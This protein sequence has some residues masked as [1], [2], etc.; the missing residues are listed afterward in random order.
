MPPFEVVASMFADNSSKRK[1]GLHKVELKESS[2]SEQGSDSQS[3]SDDEETESTEDEKGRKPLKSGIFVKASSTKIVKSVL[4]AQAMVD[5]E[6]TFKGTDFN[7]HE[8][9]FALWVA[10]EMEIILSKASPQEK[11]TRLNL[12]KHLAYKSIFLENKCILSQYATF[13][14]KVE[15]GRFKWGSKKAIRHLDEKLRFR[16]LMTNLNTKE[17]EQGKFVKFKPREIDAGPARSS[18]KFYCNE[19]NKAG[20]CLYPGSHE[21]RFNKLLVTKTHMC[22][23]CWENDGIEAFHPMGTSECRYKY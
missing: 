19:Y 21:G 22:R 15:K 23:K 7:F 8:L 17:P 3:S 14:G 20:G 18:Q 13:L 5:E 2:E 6:E 10:G 1:K 12:M 11:W 4:H 16:T 9:P